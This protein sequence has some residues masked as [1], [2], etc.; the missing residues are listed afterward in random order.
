[1]LVQVGRVAVDFGMLTLIWLVQLIIYPSFEFS[2]KQTFMQWHERYTGMI[3]LVVLPL[4][5]AQISL[6]IWQ[7]YSGDRSWE[8]LT[9]LGLIGFCWLVTFALSVPAHNQL[10]TLGNDINTVRWLVQT[11]WLR[12]IAWTAVS[13]LSIKQ[14]YDMYRTVGLDEL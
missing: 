1:M 7:V 8:T 9:A 4:M 5:L 2:A 12:T 11:N 14:F 13:V 6:A 10:Q 3:T